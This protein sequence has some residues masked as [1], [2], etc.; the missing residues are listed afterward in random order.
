M[1]MLV[2]PYNYYFAEPFIDN[3]NRD[4]SSTA[5]LNPLTFTINSDSWITTMLEFPVATDEIYLLANYED[6]PKQSCYVNFYYRTSVANNWIKVAVDT[7]IYLPVPS[8][9]A[10]IKVECVY[11]GT[12]RP[13]VYD[14]A[15][16]VK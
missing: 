13:T 1:Y 8:K 9:F 3:T 11:S 16:M 15:V 5:E 6:Y 4:P 2:S 14:F 7:P 10:Q 12:V